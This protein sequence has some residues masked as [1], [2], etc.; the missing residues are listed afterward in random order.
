M[1]AGRPSW[2]KQTGERKRKGDDGGCFKSA[3]F[4]VRRWGGVLEHPKGSHAWEHFNLAK[5]PRAGGWIKAD[6][7][8]GWTCCVEQGM[9]G[10]YC[11]KPTWLYAVGVNPRPELRWGETKI[12]PEHF[13]AKA[14]EKYG[15]EYC[16]K[17]GPMAF[18]GGGTDSTA[19][20]ATPP[21]FRDLLIAMARSASPSQ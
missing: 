6:D 2:I 15:W 14:L 10:H 21:E 18:R 13:P 4:D 8:G 3:L 7:F 5:P 17:A 16:K 9:Y 20:I 12:G 19:R 1:W 11:P